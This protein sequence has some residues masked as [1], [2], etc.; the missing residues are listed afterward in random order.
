MTVTTE[1][2]MEVPGAQAATPKSAPPA[3]PIRP[4]RTFAEPQPEELSARAR[5][6]HAML[7]RELGVDR[8]SEDDSGGAA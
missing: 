8:G 3:P 5:E 1:G 7:D 6:I 2:Q 4:A